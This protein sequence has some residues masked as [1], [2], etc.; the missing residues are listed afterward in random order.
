MYGDKKAE[1][2]GLTFVLLNAI[3]DAVVQRRVA[4]ADVLTVLNQSIQG[5]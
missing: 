4:E 3:G 1:T 5:E 2:G